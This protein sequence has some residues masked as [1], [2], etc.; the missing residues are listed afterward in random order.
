MPKTKEV[1]RRP[2]YIAAIIINAI[3]IYVFNNL[4]NWG[5]PFLTSDYSA[6]LWAIDI[7][8]GA[9]ILA[10]ITYLFI[11]S[12]WFRHLG[13]LIL[14]PISIFATYMILVIFPFTFAD[15]PWAF[16]IKV[17]LIIVMAACGIGFSVE[18]VNLIL[19]KD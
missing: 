19:R 18:L 13:Q 17:T 2:G 10:N 6:V 5:V 12:S 16:W 8:L 7:S 11:D 3:L 14:L 4:L 1:N 9:S 15:E